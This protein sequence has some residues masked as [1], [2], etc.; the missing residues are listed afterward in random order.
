MLTTPT[1]D[2]LKGL[3]LDAFATAWQAPPSTH[4]GETRTP[5]TRARIR[6]QV[7]RKR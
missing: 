6:T 7:A 5:G 4:L 1:L 3:R 2:R